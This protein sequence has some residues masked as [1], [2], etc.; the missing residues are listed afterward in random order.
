MGRR[1]PA[2]RRARE[3]LARPPSSPARVSWGRIASPRGAA[4]ANRA[5]A[6][7]RL[8]TFVCE[9]DAPSETPWLSERPLWRRFARASTR[10]ADPQPPQRSPNQNR[11][12]RHSHY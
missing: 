8:R 3:R 1:P 10:L 4:C 6:Y 5:C 11:E 2:E 9:R 7:Y 12:G